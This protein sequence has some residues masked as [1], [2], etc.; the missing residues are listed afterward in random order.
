M[1]P[2]SI[3]GIITGSA[4]LLKTLLDTS[5]GLQSTLREIKA[6]D[7]ATE[8]LV[9]ELELFRSILLLFETELR[10]GE[11]VPDVRRWWDPSRLEELLSNAVKTLSRLEAIV[12]DVG[13][14]RS[15]LSTL[16]QYWRSK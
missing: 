14:E 4:T 15:V 6:I 12:K 1:D 2:A 8:E 5:L 16:R 13:K 9:E 7:G 10:T 11:L 3:V